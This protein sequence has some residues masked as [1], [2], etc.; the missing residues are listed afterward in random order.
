MTCPSVVNM[1]HFHDNPAFFSPPI[2]RHPIATDVTNSYNCSYLLHKLSYS[3][4]YFTIEFQNSCDSS[5]K[6]PL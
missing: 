5:W 1:S 6:H 4:K 2:L 3:V